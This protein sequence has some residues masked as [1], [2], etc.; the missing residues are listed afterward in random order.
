MIE[1][2]LHPAV[3][4]VL[5][6]GGSVLAYLLG[7]LPMLIWM[8]DFY[9]VNSSFSL[10]V[11]DLWLL[12]TSLISAWTVILPLWRKAGGSGIRS[13]LIQS[14][15]LAISAW[16]GLG[17]WGVLSR[18]QGFYFAWLALMGVIIGWGVFLPSWKAGGWETA[19]IDLME[20]VAVVVLVCLGWG[21]W[22]AA[23]YGWFLF[24]GPETVFFWLGLGAA[25]Y[26]TYKGNYRRALSLMLWMVEA[27]VIE[28]A[29]MYAGHISSS[30]FVYWGWL[31]G[32]V[33]LVSAV[34]LLLIG[35]MEWRENKRTNAMVCW[36]VLAGWWI[37]L[38]AA[39]NPV[40]YRL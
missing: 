29:F 16:V 33:V 11:L 9:E 27:S 20:S 7:F 22:L 12:V 31:G 5:I 8:G 19:R 2:K 10:V 4:G 15:V 13:D 25:F 39:L 14:T 23:G 26:M 32:L 3:G 34:S 18:G 1:K 21:L 30:T 6:V 36:V 37:W 28:R 24:R 40:L 38:F 17:V 35:L